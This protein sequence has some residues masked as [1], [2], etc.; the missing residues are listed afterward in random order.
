MKQSFYMPDPLVKR[1]KKGRFFHWQVD[2]EDI[3]VRFTET[4]LLREMRFKTANGEYHILCGTYKTYKS[5]VRFPSKITFTT[6]QKSMY[7][8]TAKNVYIIDDKPERFHKRLLRYQ[9]YK[10][11]FLG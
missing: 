9:K 5:G 11:E 2:T 10:A 4:N 7:E 8:I 3:F 6:P 1:V